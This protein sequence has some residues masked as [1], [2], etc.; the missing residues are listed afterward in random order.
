M[1]MRDEYRK[2]SRISGQSPLWIRRDDTTSLREL[3]KRL[4]AISWIGRAGWRDLQAAQDRQFT[5]ARSP[6]SSAVD[7]EA[8]L[9]G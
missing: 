9:C 5:K 3:G 1:S 7:R 4:R 8:V 2:G 6:R